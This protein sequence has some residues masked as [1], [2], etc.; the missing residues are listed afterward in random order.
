MDKNKLI[1]SLNA[2][3]ADERLNNLKK[4]KAVLPKER[5]TDPCYV[6]NHVHTTYSFSPYS[7]TKAAYMAYESG[8]ETVGIMDHDSIGGA[9][10][11]IEAGRILGIPTT[12]GLEARVNFS[13]TPFADRLIN[14]PDQKG[15]AYMA[16]HGIAHGKIDELS[17]FFE[18]LRNKR[19][20]RNRKMSENIA[21]V[22]ARFG[23]D[24]DFGRDVL[25]H[26]LWDKGGS[27]T[28]R[29]LCYALAV[30]IIEKFGMGKD[31]AEFIRSK[32][33]LDLSEK[34]FANLCDGKN[35]HY[36]YDLLGALKSG[37]VGKFYIPATDECLNIDGFAALGKRVG[38]IAAYAYLGD[39]KESPTGD[40]KA[41]KFEDDYLDELFAFLKDKGINAVAYMPSRNSGQQLCVLREKCA[42]YGFFEISGEDINSSRQSFICPNLKNPEFAHLVSATWA[43]IGHEKAVSE[44]FGS[45]M[46]SEKTVEKMPSLAERIEKYAVI[47]RRD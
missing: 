4:L 10:E 40:K 46:F 31:C 26:T 25:P 28:E 22:V 38:A 39:V 18:P 35:P 30:K 21:S 34:L 44:D 43:L 6:N 19:N 3:S 42:K 36:V 29:T 41:Q 14:N 17:S 9:K 23:I 13:N 20:E 11:F 24:F 33:G 5:T 7:P 16:L 1:E 2:D 37:L 45:G 12:I 47:G 27:V 32:L 8:L 15:V